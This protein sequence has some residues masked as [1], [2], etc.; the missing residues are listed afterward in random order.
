[1][2]MM[3]QADVD[4]ALAR[5]IIECQHHDGCENYELIED[6][7]RCLVEYTTRI[8]QSRKRAV[9]VAKSRRCSYQHLKVALQTLRTENAKLNAMLDEANACNERMGQDVAALRCQCEWHRVE[10]G[11]PEQDKLVLLTVEDFSGKSR[12]ILLYPVCIY[13]RGGW[14][15]SR[16]G[17]KLALHGERP[18]AWRYW[19]E[20]YQPKEAER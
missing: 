4:E 9:L 20:T 8:R 17:W 11:L 19:P 18:Y 14:H 7:R 2:Y 12:R 10:E 1:M 13:P 5:T 15:D 16:N 6:L 3:T